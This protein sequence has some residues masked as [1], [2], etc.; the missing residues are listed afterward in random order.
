MSLLG[1]S[2]YD[3]DPSDG[4]EVKKEGENG[5]SLSGEGGSG[6]STLGVA[7]ARTGSGDGSGDDSGS[8]EDGDTMGGAM[9]W[10]APP[11]RDKNAKIFMPLPSP[12]VRL[13]NAGAMAGRPSE[14]AEG[15]GESQQDGDG[16]PDGGGEGG[17]GK[18]EVD[19]DIVD[20][21]FRDL[22]PPEPEGSPN[23]ELQARIKGFLDN[24]KQDLT[25]QMK[26]KKEYGNPAV[27]TQICVYMSVD[28]K[29]TNYPEGSKVHPSVYD[30]A[31]FHDALMGE[32]RKKHREEEQ[33][34]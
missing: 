32:M 15:R 26:M 30:A 14:T 31:D 23:Q 25:K 10:G 8:D 33:K 20:P 19:M 4:G 5:R 24:I 11:P 12:L 27:L 17:Q 18:K 29:G 16:A 9:P 28:D 2:G 6:D 21:E 13:D 22:L 3:S 1:L 7:V 34:S